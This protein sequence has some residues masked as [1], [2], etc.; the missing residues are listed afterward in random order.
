MFHALVVNKMAEVAMFKC[1]SVMWIIIHVAWS[2]S[3][4]FY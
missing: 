3:F 4:G 2:V 1:I